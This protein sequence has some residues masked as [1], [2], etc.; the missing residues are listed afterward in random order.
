MFNDCGTKHG[1]FVLNREV[2]EMCK[3]LGK[4]LKDWDVRTALVR[5][6]EMLTSTQLTTVRVAELVHVLSEMSRLYI[7]EQRRSDISSLIQ[8]FAVVV[9]IE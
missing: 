4:V 2:M 7:K 8:M 1:D 6:V 3:A 5:V 9:E